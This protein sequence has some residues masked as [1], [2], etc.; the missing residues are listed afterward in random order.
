[1]R[2]PRSANL[3][4]DDAIDIF[5]F[6][7]EHSKWLAAIAVAIQGAA[8]D[9][10]NV[11]VNDLANLAQYLAQDCEQYMAHNAERLQQELDAVGGVPN[12]RC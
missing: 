8:K 7:L 5:G 10:K 12:E 11:L 9:G 4:A 3:I 1:M 2:K 6:A